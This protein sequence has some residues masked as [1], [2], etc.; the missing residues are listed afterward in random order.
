[1]QSRILEQAELICGA[2]GVRLTARRKR[3][4]SIVCAHTR[5]MGAYE[6][7]ERLG[8][9]IKPPTV[10]RALAFL[11]QQGLVHRLESLN[12]F[13]G[14]VHPDHPH[15]GQ[16]LICRECGL[17]EELEDERVKRILELAVRDSGF[18]ADSQVVEVTGRCSGC[19]SKAR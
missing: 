11:Q 8:P 14:C 6:I 2:K 9:G 13:V 5:P 10:Y 3:V 7:L 12:A 1:M 19:L 4:L 16:F 18:K 15:A 17:V